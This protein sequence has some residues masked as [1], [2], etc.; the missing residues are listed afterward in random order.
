[1]PDDVDAGARLDD[2]VA[3]AAVAE[4]EKR[5]CRMYARSR[6]NESGRVCDVKKRAAPTVISPRERE[7][8]VEWQRARSSV[9]TFERYCPQRLLN[10]VKVLFLEILV[11]LESIDLIRLRNSQLELR[12]GTWPAHLRADDDDRNAEVSRKHT[13]WQGRVGICYRCRCRGRRACRRF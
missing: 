9:L 13:C 2:A 4:D 6:A 11:S 7:S 12:L 5:R 1:M 3:D 10:V 8:A